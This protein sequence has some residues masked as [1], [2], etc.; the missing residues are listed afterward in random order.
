MYDLCWVPSSRNDQAHYMNDLTLPSHTKE[1]HCWRQCQKWNMELGHYKLN[2]WFINFFPQNVFFRL[3]L[4]CCQQTGNLGLSILSRVQA[5]RWGIWPQGQT[6]ASA[7]RAH[8]AQTSAVP[9]SSNSVHVSD[10]PARAPARP[11]LMFDRIQCQEF[12]MWLILWSVFSRMIFQSCI[13][14]LS[15]NDQEQEVD[16]LQCFSLL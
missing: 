13:S 2:M 8:W 11:R 15:I 16:V 1:P 12:L 14:S 9:S 4:A 7:F 5:L 10:T 6:T 3:V